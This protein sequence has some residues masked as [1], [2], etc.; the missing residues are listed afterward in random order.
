MGHVLMPSVVKPLTKPVNGLL[1][2][3][4]AVGSVVKLMENG[5]A[6]EYIVVNQG[7]PSASS[8]YDASCDG[9]WLLRKD[10]Y[11]SRPWDSSNSNKYESSTIYT[12]LNEDFFNLLGPIEQSSIKQVIIPYRSGGGL[13]GTNKSGSDGLSCKIFLLGGY[14]LGWTTSNN[15]YFPIDGAVLDYFQNTESTDTK[16]IANLDGSASYWWLRTPHTFNSKYVWRVIQSGGCDGRDAS[17]SFGIRPALILPSNAV[18][19]KD[20]L[21]LKGVA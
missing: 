12:Y 6:V 3:D 2:G 17:N 7:I 4:F 5:T 11:E 10:I 19:D 16:R 14:E 13:Y 20:T 15:Q 8:L 21:I 9:L 18:F 1:A